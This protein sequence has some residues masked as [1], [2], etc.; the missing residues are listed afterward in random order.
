MAWPPNADGD[1]LR[2]LESSGFDFSKEHLVEFNVDFA[3]WPP[4]TDALRLL[5]REYP[6]AKVYEPDPDNDYPGY[7]QIQTYGRVTYELVTSIQSHV[8]E[9][10]TPFGGYCESWGV[11]HTPSVS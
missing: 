3:T 5:S 1:V 4:P 10:M 11:M 9:L 6:S 8:T 2:G 7:V